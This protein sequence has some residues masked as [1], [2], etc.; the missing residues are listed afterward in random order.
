M[1]AFSVRKGTLRK[2]ILMP[3][4][5][6]QLVSSLAQLNMKAVLENTDALLASGVPGEEIMPL[7]QRGMTLVSNSCAAGE[8]FIADLIMANHICREAID[9]ITRGRAAETG[10]IGTVLMG[11][12]QGDI[13]D[14]G[15]NLIALLLRNSNFCVIDLG[16]SVSPERFLTAVLT[17]TPD[18]LVI[19]GSLSGSEIMMAR[20]IEVIEDAGIRN[21]IRIIL[22]GNCIN[23]RQALMIGA[24]AYSHDLLDCVRLSRRFVLGEE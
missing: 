9:R 23:E 1:P 2:G 22:G 17:Y 24:D 20:T 4:N 6:E 7:L 21:T 12:V 8:Y 11:T 16:S 14:L 5:R 19:S 18:L 15:K 13:H 3:M 10:E